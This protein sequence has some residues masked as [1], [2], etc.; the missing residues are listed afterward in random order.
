MPQYCFK[1]DCGKRKEINRPMSD[2]SIP[3]ACDCGKR[4]SRDLRAEHGRVRN[5]PGTYPFDSYAL[6][7]DPENIPEMVAFDKAH[8]VQ[9][10]YN[11]DGEPR[12]TSRK[13]R[14]EYCRAHGF[15]DRNGGYSDP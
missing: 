5:I 13:H 15:H 7:V 2:S 14:R 12:L 10:H 9:T 11:E 4:M 6:G 3:L 1:C 8:N